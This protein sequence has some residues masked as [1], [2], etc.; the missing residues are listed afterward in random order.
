[1]LQRLYRQ[2][3]SLDDLDPGTRETL[4]AKFFGCPI[5]E[6]WRQTAEHHRRSGRG[7]VVDKAERDPK[8]RMALV[9]RWYFAKTVQQ[10]MEG[11]SGDRANYQ[12]H[13]GPALGAFNRAVRGTA[14]EPVAA[15]NVDSI[16]ELLMTGAAR[17]LAS[18]AQG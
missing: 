7:D 16:A 4:E 2:H 15:R 10:A 12:I 1:V 6:V 17:V 13:C 3:A 8:H 14:L 11:A 5:D 9:F 18:V